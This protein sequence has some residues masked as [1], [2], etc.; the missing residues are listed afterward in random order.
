MFPLPRG[1]R[2]APVVEWRNGFPYT[3]LNEYQQYASVPNAQF[4]PTF[5]SLDARVSERDL[6]GK[7]GLGCGRCGWPTKTPVESSE[8]TRAAGCWRTTVEGAR[9]SADTTFG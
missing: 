9:P 7:T 8:M 4:L 1:L 5:F 2:F 6:S 3:I